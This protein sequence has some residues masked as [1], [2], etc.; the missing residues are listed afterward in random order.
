MWLRKKNH[1]QSTHANYCCKSVELNF[2]AVIGRGCC[3]YVELNFGAVI[4]RGQVEYIKSQVQTSCK[5]FSKTC[6][7]LCFRKCD[8]AAGIKISQEIVVAS[9][10]PAN[11]IP[12][13]KICG[14]L[15]SHNNFLDYLDPGR[16][17]TFSKI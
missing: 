10:C 7:H 9:K 12:V 14:A 1:P 15:A 2:G 4:G 13:V 6:A 11:H 5:V 3:K 16:C 8:M 17:V